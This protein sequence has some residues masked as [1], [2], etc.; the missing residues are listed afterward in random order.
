[1]IAVC[2]FIVLFLL[3]LPITLIIAVEGFLDFRSNNILELPPNKKSWGSRFLV[4]RYIGLFLVRNYAWPIDAIKEAREI[5]RLRREFWEDFNDLQYR[6]ER[7]RKK[8]GV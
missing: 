1:M 2:S 7:M 5:H 6:I 4:W 3:Y 8:L